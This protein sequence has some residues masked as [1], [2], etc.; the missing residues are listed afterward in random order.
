MAAETFRTDFNKFLNKEEYELTN[1]I[2][3]KIDETGLI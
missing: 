3:Y 2:L 1:V